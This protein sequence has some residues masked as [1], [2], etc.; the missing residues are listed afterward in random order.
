MLASMVGVG[1][2][3]AAVDAGSAYR[4]RDAAASLDVKPAL[5]E[6]ATIDQ[7][8]FGFIRAFALSDTDRAQHSAPTVFISVQA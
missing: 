7:M 3:R 5:S 6:F 4:A 8:P 1:L 2:M